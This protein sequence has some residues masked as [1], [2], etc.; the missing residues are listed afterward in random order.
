MKKRGYSKF[1]K[2][3][4]IVLF[5]LVL[6][7]TTSFFESNAAD[8]FVYMSRPQTSDNSGYLEVLLQNKNTESYLVQT[9]FWNC[10]ERP[11]D[12]DSYTYAVDINITNSKIEFIPYSDCCVLALS[13]DGRDVPIVMAKTEEIYTYNSGVYEIIAYKVYG[14]FG[15]VSCSFSGYRVDWNVFYTEDYTLA[16][17]LIDIY[18]QMITAHQSVSSS[19]E[20]ILGFFDNNDTSSEDDD[21]VSDLE[22]DSSNRKEELDELNKEQETDKV[23]IDD[24]SDLVDEYL[25]GASDS[26]SPEDP[27]QPKEEVTATQVVAVFVE[28]PKI[29]EM[30]MTVLSIALVAYVLFGKR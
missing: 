7:V 9:F 11:S 2:A 1:I 30:I 27:E 24:A 15:D 17:R 19:L 22:E 23:A 3:F 5:A 8:Y 29:L 13:S 26:E 21:K 12:S 6:S 10:F 14:N 20:S 28:N 25:P 4:S 18:N 16:R